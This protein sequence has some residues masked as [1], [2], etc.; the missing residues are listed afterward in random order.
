MQITKIS[1]FVLFL[2]F[3]VEVIV[4]RAN[5]QPT[6]PSPMTLV[7]TPTPIQTQTHLTPPRLHQP[8]PARTVHPTTAVPMGVHRTMTL[9]TRMGHLLLPLG[10]RAEVPFIRR[11]MALI[12]RACYLDQPQRTHPVLPL[13]L[14]QRV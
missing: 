13:D 11:Q 12:Q 4:R 5:G 6:A 3:P 8:Q 9:A 14:S 7:P 1:I 2:Y 10:L